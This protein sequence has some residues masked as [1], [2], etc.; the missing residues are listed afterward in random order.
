M[1][2]FI[3]V[4]FIAAMFPGFVS[5]AQQSSKE[6]IETSVP[7]N[8]SRYS[9]ATFAAGCFWHE[10]ALFESVK[11][12][13]DAVSGY[14]GGNAKNPDYEMVENGNTGYAESV[15]VYYDPSQISYATLLKVYFAGQDPTQ[16]N[17]QAPDFGSQYRSIAF[18]QNNAEK[19][20]IENYIK[21]LN[22][23]GKY[24]A[25]IAVQVTPLTK[26][27]PAENYHQDYIAKNPDSR[28][29]ENVSIPEI[30]KFQKE[31]PQLIKPGHFF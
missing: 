7:K 31:Y 16:T 26:F 6:N 30:K 17:G 13:V 24:S 5:C 3:G 1:K 12:V 20:A 11:G 25:P 19:T 2:S 29:V 27:W 14:A 4:I 21:Q 9:H 23:S 28:Y 15:T 18:Y 8:L 22:A 10:E